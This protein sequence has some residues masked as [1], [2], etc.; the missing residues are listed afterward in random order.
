MLLNKIFKSKSIAKD[1]EIP[2]KWTEYEKF[3]LK[4]GNTKLSKVF[5]IQPDK[6]STCSFCFYL[7]LNYIR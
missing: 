1:Y 6:V 3:E 2:S 5:E 7:V 4:Y